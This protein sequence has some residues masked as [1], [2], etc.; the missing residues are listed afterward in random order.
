MLEEFLQE[1]EGLEGELATLA[2]AML[3][4]LQMAQGR[5]QGPG[6]L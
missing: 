4:S 1:V 6:P 2:G 3:C 5:D